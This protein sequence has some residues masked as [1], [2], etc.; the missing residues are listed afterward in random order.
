MDS[1]FFFYITLPVPV[2]QITLKI[3]FE[4][5]CES[6]SLDGHKTN[7]SVFVFGC[8]ELKDPVLAVL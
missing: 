6:Q 3:D 5:V 2:R 1:C 4:C 8:Y 7:L